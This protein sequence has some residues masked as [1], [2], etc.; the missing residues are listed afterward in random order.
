MVE[1]T[2]DENNFVKPKFMFTF[3]DR[4]QIMSTSI[5]TA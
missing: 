3:V 1:V 5:A 2:I 4:K